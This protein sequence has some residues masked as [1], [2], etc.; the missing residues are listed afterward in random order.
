MK[1]TTGFTLVELMI[2]IAIIA[3]LAAV[4][5]PAYNRYVDKA[6]RI[7]AQKSLLE[8]SQAMQRFYA[9][10]SPFTYAGAT[11]GATGIYPNQVPLTG[12]TAFYQLSIQTQSQTAFTLRATPINGQIGDGYLEITST[13]E[14]RWDQDND[15]A[16]SATENCWTNYDC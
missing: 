4:S 8:A 5:Y 6:R 13:G 2:V 9:E 7:D 14:M 10:Q 15:S 1:K 12:G 3:I 11:L 16:I